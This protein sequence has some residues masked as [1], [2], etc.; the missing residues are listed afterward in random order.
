MLEKS[1]ESLNFPGN[2][3]GSKQAGLHNIIHQLVAF[4]KP[5]E[6][7]KEWKYHDANIIYIYI[8]MHI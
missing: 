6:F 4:A 2:P 3:R 5:L 7:A 8:R 1:L